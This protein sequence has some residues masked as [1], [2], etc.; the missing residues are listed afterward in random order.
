MCIRDRDNTIGTSTLPVT[1]E[2][3]WLKTP[4]LPHQAAN[5]QY[6]DDTASSGLKMMKWTALS[7]T[8]GDS[9]QAGQ[10]RARSSGSSSSTN[11]TWQIW[12]AYKAIDHAG[13]ERRWFPES[14][15]MLNA[16]N[17]TEYFEDLG[18]QI[19]QLTEADTGLI[20]GTGVIK[21]NYP[22]FNKSSTNYCYIECS[23]FK[24]Y[25]ISMSY[26]TNAYYITLSPYLPIFYS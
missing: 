25:G 20:W 13:N 10:F 4:T 6:V 15:D 8:G 18:N 12:I 1:T 14:M 9:L 23:Y 7:G 3:N 26:A 24:S 16:V 21:T 17:G 5:K 11:K 19:V 2:I 22:Q